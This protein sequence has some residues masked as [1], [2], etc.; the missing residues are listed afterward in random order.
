MGVAVS[1]AV[2]R[3]GHLGA[4]DRQ[5]MFPAEGA[6]K[7]AVI[8]LILP[9]FRVFGGVVMFSGVV[10]FHSVGRPAPAGQGWACPRPRYLFA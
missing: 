9:S 5:R 6:R 8:R 7:M 10:F 2:V 4:T 3:P 1:V